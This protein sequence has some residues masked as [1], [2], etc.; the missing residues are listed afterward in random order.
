MAESVSDQMKQLSLEPDKILGKSLEAELQFCESVKDLFLKRKFN[1]R[2]A[3]GHSY[4]KIYVTLF[5]I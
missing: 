5:F 4:S 3:L 1:Q 2:I